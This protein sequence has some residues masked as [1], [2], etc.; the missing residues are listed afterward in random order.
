MNRLVGEPKKVAL[1]RGEGTSMEFRDYARLIR[2]YWI[3]LLCLLFAGAGTGA[4]ATNLLPLSYQ[5]TSKSFV[6]VRSGS[7]VPDLAQGG[8]YIQ[9]IVSSYAEIANTPYV[10]RAVRS[11]LGISTSVDD[12]SKS[13]TAAAPPDTAI[14]QVTATASSPRLSS[15]L[16][17]AT[18]G[19]LAIAVEKLSSKEH[20]VTVTQIQSATVPRTPV[21]PSLW[22][23]VALGLIGGLILAVVVVLL[24]ET[25]N[26]RVRGPRDV[27][28]II[29]GPVLGTIPVDGT[30]RA[31]N[32]VQV[33]SLRT[34]RVAAAYRLVRAN[35]AYVAPASEATTWV[36]TSS[37]QAE[38]KTL[39][40]ISLAIAEAQITDRV[41]LVDADFR[42]P[43]LADVFDLEGR[44]GL[45]DVLKGEVQLSDAIH[46]VGDGRLAV[47]PAGG[48][49]TLPQEL[50]QTK[51]AEALLSSLRLQFDVVIIDVPP[52]LETA[53]AI[54]LVR[55]A[56]GVVVIAGAGRVRKDQ[57]DS[58]L[59]LLEQVGA[60]IAGVI[61]TFVPRRGPD[62]SRRPRYKKRRSP[63]T[64]H[65]MSVQSQ[66]DTAGGVSGP[67]AARSPVGLGEGLLRPDAP[68][69]SGN[70]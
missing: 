53:E 44:P 46:R 10:L 64:A 18:S 17:N 63:R 58:A 35:L 31:K 57:L 51:D 21:S 69:R 9:Q 60:Q 65:S 1:L 5:A 6:A 25:L 14:I 54:G 8:T 26:T 50:L 68:A 30:V 47:L 33:A 27:E 38:G 39:S 59:L 28:Q 37:V 7:S 48:N 40:A 2:R 23:D 55:G 36:V 42:D 13:I 34:S 11:D 61:V 62:S 67:R 70:S 43:A 15:D 4:I 24:R 19:E 20:T 49:G 66:A 45:C 16:A 32:P 29:G 12:L 22:L 41:L 56:T 52:L 3:L